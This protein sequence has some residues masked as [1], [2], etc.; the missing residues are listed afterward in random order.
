MTPR[1]LPTREA[2]AYCGVPRSTLEKHGPEPIKLGR[3]NVYET[4]SLDAW[5]DAQAGITARQDTQDDEA[6][7]LAA[8]DARKKAR[9]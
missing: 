9:G 2:A 3:H 8:I 6:K 7:A 1:C 4:S 5:I